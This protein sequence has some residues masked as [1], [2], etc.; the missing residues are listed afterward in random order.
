MPH[1]IPA[2][3][4]LWIGVVLAG[5]GNVSEAQTVE[6]PEKAASDDPA[7]PRVMENLVY[8]EVAGKK[9]ELDL[10]K[11]AGDGPFPALVL[12]HGGGW[13]G[14]DR[15]S[16]RVEIERAARF[17]YT[18][19]TISYR[20]TNPNK[21][22][23]A[24]HPFPAQIHDVKQA[25]RWLRANAAEHKVDPTRIGV[26]GA[27]AGGHLSL[28][29]G[30]TDKR[31]GLEGPDTP[32]NSD[33]RVQAVVNYF[34]PTDFP[35]YEDIPLVQPLFRELL[36]GAPEEVPEAYKRASPVTYATSDDP[37]V[38]T[39][40]G[41]ADRIVPVSQ[42]ELLDRRMKAVGAR[43]ELVVF[44]GQGHGFGVEQALRAVKLQYEFF[45][46]HLKGLPP[47]PTAPNPAGG[48]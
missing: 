22:G 35:N 39:L 2:V 41:D 27:S 36:G 16:Y 38:L 30:L 46:K 8:S 32:A 24:E 1:R 6:A 34:G 45:E 31:S 43:H 33:T 14:G 28:L 21:D 17:G 5:I 25:I 4:W 19:V 9:L 20:L 47:A 3:S 15:K 12:I 26:M 13:K 40:H 18:A 7:A 37:P 29:A 42:A 11:P 10:A 44:Q 23:K 48:N